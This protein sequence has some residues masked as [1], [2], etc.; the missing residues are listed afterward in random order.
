MVLAS[1]LMPVSQSAG[2]RPWVDGFVIFP[3]ATVLLGLASAILER[4]FGVEGIAWAS[5]ASAIPLVAIQLAALHLG[6]ILHLRHA[7][8]LMA[9]TI[10]GCGALSLLTWSVAP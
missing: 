2:S 9:V 7:A 8:T 4:S 1:W 5:T 3:L 10:A 6:K